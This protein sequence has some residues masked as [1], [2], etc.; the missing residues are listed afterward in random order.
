M[1][2]GENSLTQAAASSIANGSP[3]SRA[4]IDDRV[5]VIA[6]GDVR[7]DGEGAI[8]EQRRSGIAAQRAP[9]R[10]RVG[11][12]AATANGIFLFTGDLQRNGS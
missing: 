10:G 5:G 8:D 4:Q 6:N 2:R 9:H 12:D 3:S 11:P 7:A 1:A